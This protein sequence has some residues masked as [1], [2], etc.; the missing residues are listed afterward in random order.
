MWKNKVEQIENVTE[1]DD[2]EVYENLTHLKLQKLIYFAQGIHLAF[3]G[4]PL[5]NEKIEAWEHGPVIR[6][7]YDSFKTYKRNDINKNLSDSELKKIQDIE[8]DNTASTVLNFV[9]K[10]FGVYT[11]W[12]LRELSHIQNGPWEITVRE[13]GMNKEIS[14]KSMENY[15][16][17]Y[18]KEDA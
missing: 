3:T 15:F 7:V 10:N 9:Y 13:N 11:A 2:Y 4:K 8:S 16:Q 17:K 12:Q 18:I 5:F 14:K 6:K 1:Y